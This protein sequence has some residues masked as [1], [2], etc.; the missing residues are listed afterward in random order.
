MFKEPWQSLS[1]VLPD[2]DS[3]KL[4]IVCIG[5]DCR[6]T[7]PPYCSTSSRTFFIVILLRDWLEA[8]RR[9][10][11]VGRRCIC[12]VVVRA[13]VR[14][15]VVGGH[16]EAVDSSRCYSRSRRSSLTSFM[17]VSPLSAALRMD[18]G[19]AQVAT[20]LL[21]AGNFLGHQHAARQRSYSAK[22]CRSQVS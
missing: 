12:R 11:C 17:V 7:I 10:P 16:S 20:R 5:S 18:L 8:S 1:A 21:G 14:W 6:W 2:Y 13:R 15:F 9:R 4:T 19:K 22:S 3:I